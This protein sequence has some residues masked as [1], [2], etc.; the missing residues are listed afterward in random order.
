MKKRLLSIFIATAMTAAALAGCG[1]AGNGGAETSG[2]VSNA[3]GQTAAAASNNGKTD[4]VVAMPDDLTTFDPVGTSAMADMSILKLLYLRLYT[5][6]ENQQPVPQLC[7]EYTK[8]SDTEHLFKIYEGVKFEDGTEVT[9]EDVAYCL[10]RAHESAIFATLMKSVEKIEAV[11]NYTVKITTS[12]AAPELLV[13]LSHSGTCILP[14]SYVEQA[15]ASGNWNE[16]VCSAQYTLGVRSLG[17]SVVIKKNENYFDEETAAKNTS[18]TFKYVPEASSR[19]VMVQTGEADVNYRFNTTEYDLVSADPNVE[20]HSTSGTVIQYFGMSVDKAPFDNKLVRQ[21]VEYAINR[22]DVMEVVAEGLGKVS[23]TVVPPTSLGYVENPG[24]YTYDVE[25]AKALLTEAGFPNGFDTTIAVFNDTGESLAQVV[26]VYLAQI[27][28]NAQISRYEASVRQS[29]FDNNE[30]ECYCLSW[31]AEPDPE[32]V[33][34][35]L[36][37]QD[38]IG[39]Y[40]YSHYSNDQV[41]KLLEDARGTSDSDE[42]AKLYGEVQRI[43]MEDAPWAPCYVADTFTVTH[44]GL[45]G[46]YVDGESIINLHEL[47][48]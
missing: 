29:M 15:V 11:D 18:I 8:P 10:N 20:L 46:V 39:G 43:I 19:T 12:G 2:E 33:Y 47:H 30:I 25:K 24:N 37:I 13:A 36:F 41:E 32:L 1:G 42:R 28:I 48:Y 5:R 45:Q 40:N 38:A 35:R 34:P 6:D 27:G 31:G 21:A 3:A 14:K 22:E 23:Y 7:E 16:P 17:D 9:A 26:Q 44:A 4:L